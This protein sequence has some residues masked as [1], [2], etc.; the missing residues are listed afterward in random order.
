M[1]KNRTENT[2]EKNPAAQPVAE[3]HN[4]LIIRPDV[5]TLGWILKKLTALH[6][7]N[8]RFA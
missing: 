5:G 8:S 4:P 2:A 1:A 7:G 3:A 6:V